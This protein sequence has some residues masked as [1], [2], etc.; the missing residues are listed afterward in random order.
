MAPSTAVVVGNA[1]I[2]QAIAWPAAQPAAMQRQLL[3]SSTHPAPPTQPRRRPLPQIVNVV[4]PLR[5]G[6]DAALVF[7]S[8]PAVM[9]LNKLGTFSMS[10]LGQS[11]SIFSDFIKS[12]RQSNDNFEEGLLKLVRTLPKVLKFLP[13]DKAQ[14]ARNFVNA[15]Q[16]W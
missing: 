10:Q 13:S 1:L 11:K 3:A 12:Q 8:M 7:P 2:K 14:D 6:L 9:K 4:T 15:L 5:D 16:Y